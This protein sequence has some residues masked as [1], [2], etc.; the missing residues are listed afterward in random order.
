MQRQNIEAIKNQCDVVQIIISTGVELTPAGQ[1]WC[2]LCPFHEEKSASFFIFPSGFWKCFGCSRSG[3]IITFLQLRNDWSFN[4]TVNFLKS[5]NDSAIPIKG[6]FNL[7]KIEFDD[8]TSKFQLQKLKAALNF[9]SSC[10]THYG[11]LLYLNWQRFRQGDIQ[12]V[13]FYTVDSILEFILARLDMEAISF[14][15]E[16]IALKKGWYYD[17]T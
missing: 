16:L 14:V 9:N 17:R 6:C 11:N 1:N 13:H 8:D 15:H 2:G 4:K 5:K 10:R 12:P 7:H 3:D